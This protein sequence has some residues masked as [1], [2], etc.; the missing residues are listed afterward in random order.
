MEAL[1]GGQVEQALGGVAEHEDGGVG[2]PAVADEMEAF[3]DVFVRRVL[4]DGGG[5]S[6]AGRGDEPLDLVGFEVSE[7][8]GGARGGIEGFGHD[9]RYDT[10]IR[11]A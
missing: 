3:E 11:G 5:A 8:G 7:G 6:L 10:K 9:E 1:D 2:G 4:G